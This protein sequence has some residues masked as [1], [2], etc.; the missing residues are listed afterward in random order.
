VSLNTLLQRRIA[1]VVPFDDMPLE[2]DIWKMAHDHHHLH[3]YL[4][5]C[6]SHRPGIVSGLEVVASK[7]DPH[8][9]IVTAG[10]AVDS[11]GHTI[12]VPDNLPKTFTEAGLNYL[13]LTYATA[14]DVSSQYMVKLSDSDVSKSY[15]QVEE[16][17]VSIV[18]TLPEKEPFVELARIYRD[19]AQ[20]K[21]KN[22]Q[23]PF[24][25]KD[26]ELDLLYRTLSFPACVLDATVGE[27]AY[28]P[29]GKAS[30]CPNH[31]G[32]FHLIREGNLQGMHLQFAGVFEPNLEKAA[33]QNSPT[34]LYLAGSAAIQKPEEEEIAAL[35]RYLDEGGTLIIEA[36]SHTKSDLEGFTASIKEMVQRLGVNWN[37]DL[38][39]LPPKHPLLT[40]HAIFAAPPP[41]YAKASGELK[42]AEDKGII[43]TTSNYGGCWQGDIED[44]ADPM[45]RMR[46]R[47]A[48]E[49]GLNLFASAA[50]RRHQKE[51]ANL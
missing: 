49:F 12:V 39:D 19:G 29:T 34:L 24:D 43:F 8:S 25:P 1:G 26:N 30:W 32:L 15:C 22:A 51:L 46:I 2:P 45:A 4:H 10:V 9:V 42:I 28:L 16:H 50:K 20:A 13:I 7:N 6:A 40:A 17:Y 11:Q 5:S 38:I 47:Q 3:R 48:Q 31:A 18:K 37:N 14:T 27:F 33:V 41:G 21:I 23:D 35:R 44:P 36:V